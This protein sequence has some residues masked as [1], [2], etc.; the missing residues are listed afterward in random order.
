MLIR[1]N[2]ENFLSFEDNQEFSMI[3]GHSQNNSDRLYDD[4]TLKLIKFAAIYGANASGKSNLI[5]AIDFARTIVLREI[6]AKCISSYSKVNTLNKNKISSFEFEIKLHGHYYNYGFE[7]L[8]SKRS[9]K[10]EWLYEIGKAKPKEIYTRDV[11]KGVFS[12]N[13]YFKSPEIVQKLNV[14]IDVIKNDDSVLFLHDINTKKD[15]LY[16]EFQEVSILRDIFLW[17]LRDLDV[18]YANRSLKNSYTNIFDENVSCKIEK[19]L[20]LF[21]TGVNK[22]ITKE[23]SREDIKDALPRKILEDVLEEFNKRDEPNFKE[24]SILVS[25]NNGGFFLFEL[26]DDGSM[27][28]KILQFNHGEDDISLLFSEESDGTKRLMELLTVLLSEEEGKVFII[29]EI[30]RCLHPL[31]SKK[32]VKTFLE[33][34]KKKNIQLIVTTHESQLMDFNLLRKDEIWMLNKTNKGTTKVY[35]LDEFNERFDKKIIRA[36]LDGRYGG[37]PQFD[38]NTIFE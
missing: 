32:Y 19:Y 4:G 34:A 23:V 10:S 13:N 25:F 9:I 31:L 29:D 24:K 18:N 22:V 2:V 17:F 14:F 11:E 33:I 3:A 7:I 21:G 5:K 1:F 12:I 8:L 26:K 36:Y 15:S 6:P 28:Y 27:V 30:D 37:I 38:N 20:R 16:K 35:S